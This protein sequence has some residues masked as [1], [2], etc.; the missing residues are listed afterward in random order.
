MKPW[1]L[2][3]YSCAHNLD[4]AC[5]KLN[6]K[7]VFTREIHDIAGYTGYMPHYYHYN[8]D[9]FYLHTNWVKMINVAIVI[10]RSVSDC[11]LGVVTGCQNQCRYSCTRNL[12]PSGHWHWGHRWPGYRG[13]SSSLPPRDCRGDKLVS[14]RRH[15]AEGCATLSLGLLEG[16][17]GWLD[18]WAEQ[19]KHDAYTVHGRSTSIRS[20]LHLSMSVE[21]I[22]LCLLINKVEA[23]P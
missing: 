4:P 14:G 6:S 15:R 2:F 21:N 22:K 1:L 23:K 9:W 3:T 11:D 18:T 17:W 10:K 13:T 19:K 7:Q 16:R 5:C 8:S 12:D 20:I